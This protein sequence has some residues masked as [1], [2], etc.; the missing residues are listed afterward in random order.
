MISDKESMF[1]QDKP[2]KKPLHGMLHYVQK[3]NFVA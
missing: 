3:Y 2:E 1:F